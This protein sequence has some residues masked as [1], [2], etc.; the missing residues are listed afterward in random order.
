MSLPLTGAGKSRG[1]ILTGYAI[2][3]NGTSTDVNC[4]SGATL[5]DIPAAGAEITVGIWFRLDTTDQAGF[6]WVV[7]KGSWSSIG[8]H[9]YFYNDGTLRLGVRG[10]TGLG[11]AQI[12]ASAIYNDG[13]WHYA[14]GYYNDT[15]K[16]VRVSLDGVWDSTGAVAVGAY[17][18]DAAQDLIFG[19][20]G[21]LRWLPGATA[22]CE[23]SDN[24]RH[25]A[26]SGFTPPRVPYADGNTVEYWL[27]N[28]GAG[29]TAAASVTTPGNDGTISNGTWET[30]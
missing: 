6:Y 15:T 9:L 22:W 1:E 21:A 7:S 30:L 23:I 13:K 24:N 20:N 28:E 16:S 25:S 29:A 4:G 8:W 5:N 3:F 10:A 12:D 11:Q 27:M 18:S 26:G 19:Q 17:V 2:T 14:A